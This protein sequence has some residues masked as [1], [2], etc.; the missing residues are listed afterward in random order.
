MCRR[1]Q[2]SRRREAGAAPD[3]YHAHA[4][5]C[6]VCCSCPAGLAPP[7]GPTRHIVVDHAQRLLGDPLLGVLLRLPEL[8][9]AAPAPASHHAHR[10]QERK[11]Q[12]PLM[13]AGPVAKT[14]VC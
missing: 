11:L 10:M 9:G 8:S 6:D 1:S 3:A 7:D 13:A 5:D 14:K 2:Q 4:C 12:T